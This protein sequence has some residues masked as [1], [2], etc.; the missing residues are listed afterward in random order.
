[1]LS[2]KLLSG[3]QSTRTPPQFIS[4]NVSRSDT[5]ANTVAPPTNMQDRDLLVAVGFITK[6]T[7]DNLSLPPGFSTVYRCRDSTT[8][9]SFFIAVKTASSE[10]GSY[11]FTWDTATPSVVAISVYRYA[12]RIN[13]VG[14]ITLTSSNTI[15]APGIT[16]SYLGV[17]CAAYANEDT[18]VVVSSPPSDMT[19]R[20]SYSGA[21]GTRP[22]AF[23]IYDK[24]QPASASGSKSVTL[25]GSANNSCGLLFQVTNEPDIAPEF[26]SYS[27]V[28]SSSPGPNLVVPKPSGTQSGDLML[29]FMSTGGSSAGTWS[30]DTG[31]T[32][33]AD[34][35]SVPNSRVA[36]KVAGASE[37]SSYTF[38]CSTASN[39]AS[40]CVLT[41]RYADYDTV[42]VFGT[43]TLRLRPPTINPSKS[44]SILL[45]FGSIN[46]G[47]AT[48]TATPG[49]SSKVADSD[50]T[51][52][53]YCVYDQTVQKDNL[54]EKFMLFS[55]SSFPSSGI[56]VSIKPNRS[57]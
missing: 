31:W 25:T 11:S 40:G 28:Q 24:Q 19:L 45:A 46:T 1:M 6:Y 12:T 42:G 17:L 9:L 33:L 52:P 18:G 23:V 21:S 27:S 34:Q 3:S 57:F 49:L 36:Y 38:T 5:A 39:T 53:S 2:A 15:T 7:S 30:G 47:S 50:S 8:R 26:V 14:Q 41:Y 48:V 16:P 43:G 29:A 20:T 13:S 37:P 44:Q 54:G 51:S 56:L 35:G 32:E 10:S 22:G 55:V 4:S